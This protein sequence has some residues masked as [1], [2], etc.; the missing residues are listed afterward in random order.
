VTSGP[1]LEARNVS[2]SFGGLRAVDD[3]TFG[4][5]GGEILGIVGPNGAGK[6]TLFD[7]ITGHTRPTSGDVVEAGDQARDGGLP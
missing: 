1:V 6:T 2:K 5:T 4:V 7:V 3:V